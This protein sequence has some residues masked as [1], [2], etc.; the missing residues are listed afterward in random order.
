VDG[1]R[2][3]SIEEI[4]PEVRERVRAL[5]AKAQRPGT[6]SLPGSEAALVKIE[7]D[8]AALGLDLRDLA[9]TAAPP[10]EEPPDAPP[11]DSVRT[12]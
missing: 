10:S 5:L 6:S 9:A 2:Y 1:Q 3:G 12:S 4:P 11:A 8:L 7:D